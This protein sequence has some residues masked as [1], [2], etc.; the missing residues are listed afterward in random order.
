MSDHP[1]NNNMIVPAQDNYFQLQPTTASTLTL[2]YQL[3]TITQS[4][5]MLSS[6]PATTTHSFPVITP[7]PFDPPKPSISYAPENGSEPGSSFLSHHWTTPPAPDRPP[8]PDAFASAA[9]LRSI[10]TAQVSEEPG[11]PRISDFAKSLKATINADPYGKLSQ[12]P[13]ESLDKWAVRLKLHFPELTA[14]DASAVTRAS[15]WGL[16]RR[17]VFKQQPL[18]PLAHRVLQEFRQSPQNPYKSTLQ[19]AGELRMR[20]PELTKDEVVFIT[21]ANPVSLQN[22]PAFKT[23]Q[24][25]KDGEKAMELRQQHPTRFPDKDSAVDRARDWQ[26]LAA[27]NDLKLTRVDLMVLADISAPLLCKH[28]ELL[29]PPLSSHGEFVKQQIAARNPRFMPQKLQTSAERAASLLALSP[30][31]GTIDLVMLTGVKYNTAALLRAL[32]RKS[33][34]AAGELLKQRMES[35]SW[36]PYQPIIGENALDWGTRVSNMDYRLTAEDIA[37]INFCS[38]YTLRKR[39]RRRSKLSAPALRIMAKL[40]SRQP[41]ELAL[42]KNEYWDLWFERLHKAEPQLTEQELFNIT[43]FTPDIQLNYPANIAPPPVES[44]P[45][46]VKTPTLTELLTPD[47]AQ[48]APAATSQASATPSKPLS[49]AVYDQILQTK[50]LVR[51]VNNGDTHTPYRN[52]LLISLL[53]HATG[54]YTQSPALCQL[55]NNY[56]QLLVTQGWLGHA[57]G[58]EADGYMAFGQQ[59][60]TTQGAAAALL[61]MINANLAK[62]GLLP[63]RVINYSFAAGMEFEEILGSQAPDARVVHIVNT[64]EHFEALIAAPAASQA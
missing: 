39:L 58:F 23:K 24:L 18:S 49:L 45:A 32:Q 10:L 6:A 9:E 61:E 59:G 13:D 3:V 31:L 56:R 7:T 42:H 2:T 33:L 57:S 44:A 63:L 50:G 19:L 11:Q 8:Q 30:E 55:V 16:E 26:L 35:R 29:N 34:T 12:Q 22:L 60:E 25:S 1:I 54:D 64:G 37:K 4:P 14:R 62:G 20:Y 52:C 5:Q 53:Q 17:R 21:G 38:V 40:N 36:N 43:G 41:G 15:V 47:S 28:P 48:P 46:P 27:E 51:V